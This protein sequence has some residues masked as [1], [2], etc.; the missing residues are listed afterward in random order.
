MEYNLHNYSMT[1]SKTALC[2]NLYVPPALTSLT[3][4]FAH[5]VY[6]WVAYDSHYKQLSFP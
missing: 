3:L 5:T 2:G 4:H 6:L 1:K